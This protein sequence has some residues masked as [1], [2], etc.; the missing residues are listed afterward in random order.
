MHS[1]A[2]PRN[3]LR[4]QKVKP[5][6]PDRLMLIVIRVLTLSALLSMLSCAK[7]LERDVPADLL[8]GGYDEQVAS[9]EDGKR[10]QITRSFEARYP[11][12]VVSER[13]HA[14]LTA[15][16][17]KRCSGANDKWDTVFELEQKR[18]IH[19]V[20]QYWIKGNDRLLT[21]N[22]RY[23]SAAQSP[24]QAGPPQSD[25]QIVTLL[26]DDYGSSLKDV[27]GKLDIKC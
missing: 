10:L 23:V 22:M 16:G 11:T 3:W 18:L 27:L 7:S 25:V 5:L 9:T 26:V 14:A 12:M 20:T 19:Q 8:E 24:P 6:M 1:Q 13:H 17:W 15:N 4:V 2:R 21:I